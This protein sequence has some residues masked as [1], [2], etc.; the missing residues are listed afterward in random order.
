[1]DFFD[2]EA[3]TV[4]VDSGNFSSAAKKLCVTQPVLSQRIRK[5]EESL[6]YS[7]LLRQRGR[8]A[9]ELTP[10]GVIFL[11][12]AKKMLRLCEEAKAIGRAELPPTLRISINETIMTCTIPEVIQA[13]TAE[14][15]D[16]HL[17][18]HSYYSS[19]SYD[20]VNDGALDVAIVSRLLPHSETVNVIPLLKERWIFVCGKDADYPELV[21]PNELDPAKLLVLCNI[22][23]TQWYK[24]WFNNHARTAISGFTLTFLNNEGVFKNGNWAVLPGSIARYYQRKGFCETREMSA[25]PMPRMIYALTRNAESAPVEQFLDCVRQEMKKVKDAMP[26]I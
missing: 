9:I 18:L 10:Q 19:E 16:I 5:L 15:P 8:L 12:I 7:L 4:I 1:M 14:Y 24:Y 2:I 6:G 13:F 20:L 11:E 3:F 25:S 17:A 23:K 21:H 26:L 22:E